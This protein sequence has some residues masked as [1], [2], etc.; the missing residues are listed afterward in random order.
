MLAGTEISGNCIKVIHK[1][2]A[3]VDPGTWTYSRHEN[4][5]HELFF[6]YTPDQT[7]AVFQL[8]SFLLTLPTVNTQLPA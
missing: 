4:F 3:E 1:V 8:D 2:T 7:D 6:T 5:T